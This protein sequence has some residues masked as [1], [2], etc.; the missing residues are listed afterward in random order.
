MVFSNPK[1]IANWLFACCALVFAMVVVGAVTRLTESGLSIAEWKPLMGAIPPL[2]D[3]EWSR[4]F[5][6]YKQTPEFQKK[7]FWMEM[8]DFKNIFFWEWAHRFLGCAIGIFYALPL[9]YFWLRGKIPQ[10]YKF[11]L[12]VPFILGGLQG[13]MGW[14]MVQSG[15]VD[16]PAVSHYRLAA[17]LALAFLIFCVMLWLGLSLTNAKRERGAALFAHGCVTLV[18]LI[19]TIFWGAFTAGLDGGLI[20]NN[21]FPLMGDE[22]IPPEAKQSILSTPAGAQFAHRWLA[23]TTVVMALSLWAHGTLKHRGFP[24]LQAL[25]FVVVLQMGLGIATLLSGVNITIAVLHQVGALTVL[26]L[27]VMILYRLQP[28]NY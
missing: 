27:L 3:S 5:D 26:T 10:G 1:H 28:K 16:A 20:Y 18:L 21:S 8:D 15:L 4:V 17:H 7:N 13:A 19:V 9:A 11:K 24:A 25:G 6:L 12:L 14:Y 23:M 22:W 2:N